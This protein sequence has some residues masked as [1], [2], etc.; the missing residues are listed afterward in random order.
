MVDILS[1]GEQGYDRHDRIMAAS[2]TVADYNKL[3]CQI[4]NLRVMCTR[5]PGAWVECLDSVDRGG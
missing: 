5:C 2:T 3:D 4:L 1:T